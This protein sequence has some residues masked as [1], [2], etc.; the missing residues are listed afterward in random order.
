MGEAQEFYRK[1]QGGMETYHKDLKKFLKG[2]KN[3]HE[4][5]LGNVL[6]GKNI[7]GAKDV[8]KSY[9]KSHPKSIVHGVHDVMR[10][11]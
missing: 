2:K 4:K 10:P 1:L 8:T 5:A 7:E 11:K 9:K 6:K 3:P